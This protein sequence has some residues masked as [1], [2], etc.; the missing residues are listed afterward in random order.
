M[1]S[2]NSLFARGRYTPD[3]IKDFYDQTAIWWGAD[4]DIPAEDRQRAMAINR[5]G[6]PGPKRVLELG[7]G[8]GNTA[9]ATADLGHQVVAVELSPRRAAQ[10]R[11]LAGLPRKG[12]LSVIEGDFYAVELEGRFDVVCYWDG[13]GVGTDA[14]HRLLLRRIAGEWLAAGGCALIEVA[15]TAWAA[16]NAGLEE[17]LDPLEGVP[18]SVAMLRRFH[19][20]VL[21]SRWIDEWQPVEHPEHTLAQTIRC[22]TPADFLLLLEGSG[23]ALKRLEVDGQALDFTGDQISTGGPLAEAY[24]FLVQL[25]AAP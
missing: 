17:R 4:A 12:L 20:D 2:P 15:S 13:F 3:W 10:A 18:G 9:A 16:R 8:A 23:L 1:M 21:H 7:A 22:Y 25:I 11:T 5:L 19:F 14:G 6:G 24:S